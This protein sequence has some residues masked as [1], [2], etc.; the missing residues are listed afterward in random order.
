LRV[1]PRTGRKHQIR[2]HL[3]HRGHP[4]VGDKI[5]GGDEG[6]YLAF[7]EGRMSEEQRARM[8]LPCHALHA[9]RVSF[10]WR[11]REWEFL[12]KAETWM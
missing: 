11:G 6:V 7:V 3:A 10:T 12:E 9:Q 8:I 1:R 4:I 2:A 5:Y